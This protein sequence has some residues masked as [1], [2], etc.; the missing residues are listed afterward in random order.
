[1]KAARVKQKKEAY[2]SKYR[3]LA[4]RK[5]LRRPRRRISRGSP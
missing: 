2:F 3:Q 5:R 1:V 4:M